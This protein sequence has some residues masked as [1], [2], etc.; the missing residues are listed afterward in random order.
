MFVPELLKAV[1]S[2]VALRDWL[3]RDALTM[4][5]FLQ[6]KEVKRSR[7]KQKK[8]NTIFIA[9]RFCPYKVERYYFPFS[10][11]LLFFHL[12]VLLLSLAAAGFKEIKNAA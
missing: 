2:T 6:E 3:L 8:V 10:V 9:V 7:L 12:P 1:V 4:S 5:A 11:L